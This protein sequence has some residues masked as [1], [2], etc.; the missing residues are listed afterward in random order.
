M[1]NCCVDHTG[2]CFFLPGHQDSSACSPVVASAVQDLQAHLVPLYYTFGVILTYRCCPGP[3]T[4]FNPV[5]TSS[6]H[7]NPSSTS[8]Y[9]LTLLPLLLMLQVLSRICRLTLQ[10]QGA[11]GNLQ[12]V[13][14]HY[15]PGAALKVTVKLML[16][17]M[18]LLRFLRERAL[19][20]KMWVLRA[21]QQ[22]VQ[23]PTVKTDG[24]ASNVNE[25]TCP[26]CSFF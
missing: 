21:P 10:L 22:H 1:I 20:G 2:S 4:L 26:C 13:L 15:P 16:L 24:A 19:H 23:H 9:R 3:G 18:F 11:D 6:H 5:A 12:R 14:Q 17:K 25:Q 8:D 7:M